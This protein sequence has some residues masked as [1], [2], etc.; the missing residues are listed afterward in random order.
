MNNTPTNT[1]K[2]TVWLYTYLFILNISLLFI[3]ESLIAQQNIQFMHLDKDDGLTD[4]SVNTIYQDSYGYLWVGSWNGL[5]KFDGYRFEHYFASDDINSLPGNWIFT[6]FEDSQ[7]TLWVGTNAGIA[8]YDRS[9]N[10]FKQIQNTEYNGI[11]SIFQ[12]E[13]NE[14][15]CS[16]HNGI[17]VFDCEK[18][19]FIKKLDVTA[20]PSFRHVQDAIADNQGKAWIGTLDGITVMDISSGLITKKIISDE[21]NTLISNNIKTL[22]FDHDGMLWIGTEEDG[23]T[24]L[25][26]ASLKSISYKHN[27]QD[28][29]SLGSNF[30]SHIYIDNNNDAWISCINGYL[31]KY[32]RDK[33]HFIRYTGTNFHNRTIL[34]KSIDCTIQDK[35]NNYWIGSHGSGIYC[36]SSQYNLFEVFQKIPGKTNGFS[37]G[38]ITSFAE[39]D[40]NTI[41]MGNDGGGLQFFNPE[42]YNISN[43]KFN[44]QFASPNI[45]TILKDGNQL[46]C[47][48]WGGG[49]AKI[50]L[51][52]QFSLTNYTHKKE[53]NTSLNYNNIKALYAQDSSLWIGT[54]GDGLAIFD[55]NH[56]MFY[57]HNNPYNFPFKMDIPLWITDINK[58]TG[59]KMWISTVFGTFLIAQDTTYHFTHKKGDSTTIIN[60][61]VFSVYEDS[62][63]DIWVLTSQGVDKFIDSTKTFA[64]YSA[65]HAFTR[66]PKGIIEDNNGNLWI[67]ANDGVY[68][69]TPDNYS[70]RKFEKSDGIVEG[71]FQKNGAFKASDGL[72]YFGSTK[73]F[74]RCD[75]NKISS[76]LMPPLVVFRNVYLNYKLQTVDSVILTSALDVVDN[77]E[78]KYTKDIISIEI[79]AIHLSKLNQVS[80]SYKLEGYQDAWI[81]MGNNRMITFSELAPGNYNLKVRAKLKAGYQT[82]KSLQIAILPPWWMTIWFKALLTLLITSTIV[83]IVYLRIKIIKRQNELLKQ[84]V[85]ER[86]ADLTTA[87]KALEDQTEKL[88]EQNMLV[89]IKN[90]ELHEA[91]ETK[92]RLFSIIS[93]DIK[94]PLSVMQNMSQ[95]AYNNFGST[96]VEKTKEILYQLVNA[97]KSLTNLT[98]NLLDWS[99]IQTNSFKAKITECDLEQLIQEN[100]TLYKENAQKKEIQISAN[101]NHSYKVLADNTMLSTVIRNI[102]NNSIKFT[103]NGGTVTLQTVDTADYI[104]LIISDTGVGMNQATIDAILNTNNNISTYGTSNEKGTGLGLTICKEFIEKLSAK[105]AITSKENEGTEFS[106]LLPK[107]NKIQHIKAEKVAVET[108]D[109]TETDNSTII[110]IV[111]D[112]IE[113]QTYIRNIFQK[114]YRVEVASNGKDGIKLITELV[115]DIIISDVY[116]PEM[117]GLEMIKTL[118]G[119]PATNHIPVI[120]LSSRDMDKHLIEG[121]QAGADDYITKPFNR[122]VLYNKVKASLEHQNRLKVHFNKKSLSPEET[123]DVP[124]SKDEKFIKDIVKIMDSEYN[125]EDFSVEYLAGKM[126]M[127]RVQLFRKFKAIVGQSPK[128]YITQYRLEKA[129][130]LLKT[131]KYRVSDVAYEV[132]FSSPRYFSKCFV[133]YFGMAPK[134]YA[135]KSAE[136]NK[137]AQ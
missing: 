98:L 3:S 80:Y 124:E 14:L 23:L 123:T 122:D 50:E 40:D 71:E 113:I 35:E 108:D 130:Q 55:H 83:L 27:E 65:T 87:N 96:S 126:E 16:V 5:N 78:L 84:K 31:N 82:E 129:T 47:G 94:N 73:G 134:D 17:L 34:S 77:I 8:Y 59:D 15:W 58:T 6:I 11:R 26:T 114:Y 105:L 127:G 63:K 28:E 30:V 118:R 93:H 10:K 128:D 36:L 4:N 76:D 51:N 100:I 22:Q 89:V 97:T 13:T 131:Q 9:T 43:Y 115:P 117:D 25:D 49:V 112:N 88:Q 133:Q 120:I 132:G 54:H 21:S 52:N 45:I 70:I 125:K 90:E 7:N 81:D 136:K 99:V 104:K 72:L 67:T 66:Y 75:P 102:L 32:D 109:N 110:C 41:I 64:H 121:Y 12:T 18:K 106:I 37:L 95:E 57:H 56:H 135:E 60:N 48:S 20:D 68:M 92:N 62:R 116:M 44:D 86:T 101:I 1:I 79:A 69:I 85:A 137:P 2:T 24:I 61:Y 39:L 38:G 111:E 119:I 19:T 103:Y 29:H 91:N 74:M 33:K 107:G 53:T 42:T 46:W